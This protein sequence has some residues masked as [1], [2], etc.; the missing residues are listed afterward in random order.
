MTYK[1]IVAGALL[2]SVGACVVAP[3]EESPAYRGAYY[4]NPGYG[5]YNGNA[6]Y[7]GRQ[8]FY[9]GGEE[10]HEGRDDERGDGRR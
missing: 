3:Y 2:L 7:S 5:G 6:G 10:R 9:R 4:A 8:G 1:L